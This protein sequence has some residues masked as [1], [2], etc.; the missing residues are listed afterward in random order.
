MYRLTAIISFLIIFSLSSSVN[1]QEV[2]EMNRLS[3]DANIGGTNAI[4]PYATDYWSNSIGLFHTNLGARYMFNNSFGIKLDF[5]FDRLKNDEFGG[6][7]NSLG[8]SSQY[9]RTSFQLVA[10][11]SRFM[12]FE[13]FAPRFG[14]IIHGGAGYSTNK[15]SNAPLFGNWDSPDK[16]N[17][18]NFIVGLTPQFKLNS[19]WSIN[20]DIAIV[21]HIYQQRTWDLTEKV[22]RRGFDGLMTNLTVGVSYYIGS[23]KEHA[24]WTPKELGGSEDELTNQEYENRMMMV[25]KKMRDD[26]NDGIPNTIDEE[27]DTPSGAVVD[28]K[29][30]AVDSDKDGIPNQFD[31]CP[32]SAG[33]ISLDG[34][35]QKWAHPIE[36]FMEDL[37]TV[38]E[39]TDSTS[40]EVLNTDR[41]GDDPVP[42]EVEI[43]ELY[44]Y[45]ELHIVVGMFKS[46][47]N[48]DNYVE[49]LRI[50]GFNANIVG[51]SKGFKVVSVGSYNEI[52][53]AREMLKRAREEIIETAWMMKRLKNY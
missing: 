16:D 49:Q 26:D 14:L 51:I 23:K 22:N 17:M 38:A 12:H 30:R 43:Y 39:T 50:K 6:N 33:I 48:A 31:K 44:D 41:T 52:T 18:V 15:N 1:A 53:E 19:K 46:K 11:L 8:F 5:G 35:P 28:S 13:N 37:D 4:R 34:C 9:L 29:G 36:M 7:S 47:L 24:D 27:K 3:I 2:K 40:T 21:N 10:N 45:Q 32:D 20:A 25:E 42:T